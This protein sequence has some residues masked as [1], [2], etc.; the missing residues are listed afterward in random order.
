MHRFELEYRGG[1]P[2]GALAAAAIVLEPDRG[3]GQGVKAAG[4]ASA[5]LSAMLSPSAKKFVTVHEGQ[6][7]TLG[8]G[9][10]QCSMAWSLLW[11]GVE[12]NQAECV[13]SSLGGIRFQ[14]KGELFIALFGESAIRLPNT[15]LTQSR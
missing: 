8:S 13:A 5:T 4:S 15:L 14:T 6:R 12:R 1:V 11:A 7:C 9:Q 2:N 3:A 10:L